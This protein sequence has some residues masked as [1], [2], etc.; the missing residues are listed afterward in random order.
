[1]LIRSRVAAVM[2]PEAIPRRFFCDL[3]EPFLHNLPSS[4]DIHHHSQT[5]MLILGANYLIFTG[6]IVYFLCLNYSSSDHRRDETLITGIPINNP[7]IRFIDPLSIRQ[8]TP[9]DRD[10]ILQGHPVS[11]QTTRHHRPGLSPVVIG[12]T[13]DPYL[14]PGSVNPDEQNIS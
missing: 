2:Y 12:Q 6:S 13:Q 4:N 9:L 11:T 7:E 1:M 8:G 5:M 10:S 3:F 14:P